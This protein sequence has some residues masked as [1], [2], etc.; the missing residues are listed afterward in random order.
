MKKKSG[1]KHE[2]LIPVIFSR[3]Y[4]CTECETQFTPD[5]IRE[6]GYEESKDD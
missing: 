6:M 4:A 5:E 2:F 3:N 1:C